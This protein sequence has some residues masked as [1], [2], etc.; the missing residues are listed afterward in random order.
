MIYKV[1]RFQVQGSKV[2]GYKGSEVQ[3][4]RGSRVHRFK[5]EDLGK[6]SL[7]QLV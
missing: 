4:F 2:Q 7:V 5:K 3:G 6:A 1:I